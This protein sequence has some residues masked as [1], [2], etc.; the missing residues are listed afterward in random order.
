MSV[1]KFIAIENDIK[2]NE[3]KVTKADEFF[4]LLKFQSFRNF[5]FT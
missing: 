5:I 3:K 1:D 4:I 2:K